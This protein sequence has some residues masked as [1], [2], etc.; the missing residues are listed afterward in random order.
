MHADERDVHVGSVADVDAEHGRDRIGHHVAVAHRR[1]VDEP[2]TAG[3]AIA[4]LTPE[5]DREPGLPDA[6]GS[7]QRHEAVVRNLLCDRR[8]VRLPADERRERRWQVAGRRGRGL[9]IERRI[10]TEDRGL[11]RAQLDAWLD[12]DVRGQ[13]PTVHV[14]RTQR[15]DL[16]AGSIERKHVQRGKPLAQWVCRCGVGEVT[17]GFGVTTGVEEGREPTLDRRKSEGLE[18]A[19]ARPPRTRAR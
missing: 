3:I 11:D 15:F 12:T 9:Q 8:E 5:L 19:R 4:D 6:A 17:D 2:H 7:G 18:P 16:T 1:E 14:E 13:P 10:L